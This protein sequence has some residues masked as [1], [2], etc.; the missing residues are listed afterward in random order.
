MANKKPQPD[1]RFKL[2]MR[3]SFAENAVTMAL[4]H[5]PFLMMSSSA[6]H[7]VWLSEAAQHVSAFAALANEVYVKHLTGS[8]PSV[9]FGSKKRLETLYEAYLTTRAEEKGASISDPGVRGGI[10]CDIRDMVNSDTILC[11]DMATAYEAARSK[12]GLLPKRRGL[13]NIPD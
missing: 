4:R 3:R 11:R 1:E 12:P 13:H 6:Q 2:D 5:S 9:D 10:L 7:P 8:E